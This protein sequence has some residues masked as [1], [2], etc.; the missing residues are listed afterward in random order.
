MSIE[1]KLQGLEKFQRDLET[2]RK[3]AIPYAARDGLNGCAFALMR[4]W[5]RE[6]KSTFT[7]RNQYTERSIRVERAQG[8]NLRTMVA[9]TGSVA[10]YM[11]DQEQGAVIRGK[12]K[13]KAIPGPAAAGQAPGGKRTRTVRAINRLSA[14]HVLHVNATRYG[15]RRQNA[16]AI[17]VALRKGQRH[18]LLN[19]RRGGGRGLF[20]VWGTR[21]GV[22]TRLLW[23]VSRAS[24]RVDPHPTL[25]RSLDRSRA[26]FTGILSNAY[27]AQL[28]RHKVLG[29]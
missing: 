9:I 23:D 20:S 18:V 16:V 11:G 22:R 2:Y 10:P 25:Q 6:V 15:R 29:Y 5:R 1:V 17:A 3:R 24:V 14:I 12:G 21:R 13:H 26:V 4:E 19:R 28:R 7:L 8:L 27:L